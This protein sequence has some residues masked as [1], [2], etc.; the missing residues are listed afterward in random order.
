MALYIHALY[1]AIMM[2]MD[3]P[4]YKEP[5]FRPPSEADS[6]LIQATEGCTHKCTFCISNFGKKYIVRPVE[7]IKLD[8]DAAKRI[9]G[10]NVHRV[11]FLDGNAMSM[12]FDAL[13]EITKHA[14]ET[15]PRLERVGVYACGEDVLN[16][17]DQQLLALADAG[18][19]I[20]YV[21]L[22]SGDAEILKEVNKR[23]TPEQL[24]HAARKLMRSGI[25]FSGTIILGIAGTDL[26]KSHDHAI[27]TARMISQMNPD[28]NQTW[29]I[30]ALTLMIPPHT[31]ISTNVKAGRFQPM[32]EV[33]IVGELKTLIENIDDSVHDC[34]FRSNHASNYLVLKG[35][36]ANEKQAL[37]DQIDSALANPS[38]YLRP[39]FYRGL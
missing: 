39:E 12:P 36:L 33:Q 6:L 19:G 1:T 21:G 20:A 14:R 5:V 26:K 15:F 29:Y 25:T 2:S 30:G 34:I 7:E 17:T 32:D 9:H 10:P 11:F 38:R 22:E 27:N 23:T 37:L 4:Y 13:L 35:I 18:L 24:V 28:D 8:I 16:K 31:A 3:R